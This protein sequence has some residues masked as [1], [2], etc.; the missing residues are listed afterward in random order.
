MTLYWLDEFIF[1]CELAGFR[2]FGELKKYM[3]ENGLHA[4]L[5]AYRKLDALCFPDFQ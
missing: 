4:W 5:Q 2:T 3:K 1:L